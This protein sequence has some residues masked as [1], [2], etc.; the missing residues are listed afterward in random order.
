MALTGLG[1]QSH[2]DYIMLGLATKGTK[3]VV[4][5][6]GDLVDSVEFVVGTA[7]VVVVEVGGSQIGEIHQKQR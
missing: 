1:T 4:F 7:H 3:V 5:V 6:K 2:P